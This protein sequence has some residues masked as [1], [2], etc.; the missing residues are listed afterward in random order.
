MKAEDLYNDFFE[1][2]GIKLTN[3]FRNKSSSDIAILNELRSN[4]LGAESS[5][6]WIRNFEYSIIFYTKKR[7]NIS[8]VDDYMFNILNAEKIL[9]YKDDDEFFEITYDFSI[10]GGL[11]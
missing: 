10:L 7:D 3:K 2:T 9:S 8:I 11:K 6:N 5:K 4:N 1:K